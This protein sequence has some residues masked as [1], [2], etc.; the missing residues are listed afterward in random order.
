[1]MVPRLLV[2]ALISTAW[3]AWAAD[4]MSCRSAHRFE[5]R[6]GLCE[7]QDLHIDLTVDFARK[8][9]HYCVGEG[10][11]TASVA[12]VRAADGGVS[13][14]F[15]AKPEQGRSGER[16]DGLVTIHPGKK[17]AMIGNFLA[18]GNVAFSRLDCGERP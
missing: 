17:A 13:F 4:Q 2:L 8:K 18:T 16:V 12:M 1:M 7:A 11:Y 3:P 5:C 14:A 15:D 6:A 9:I 10:C